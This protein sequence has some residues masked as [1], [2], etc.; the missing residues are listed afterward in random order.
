[1]K[2]CA[3]LI[4]RKHTIHVV[5]DLMCLLAAPA[6]GGEIGLVHEPTIEEWLE[7]WVL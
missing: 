7:I 1:M 4:E 2:G 3:S 5:G 6:D